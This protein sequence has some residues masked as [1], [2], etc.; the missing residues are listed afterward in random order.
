MSISSMISSLWASM[1]APALGIFLERP[2]SGATLGVV[3]TPSM[4]R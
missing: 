2:A 3:P 1:S 4:S